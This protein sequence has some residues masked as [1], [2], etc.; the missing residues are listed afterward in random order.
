MEI[1][2]DRD[3]FSKYQKKLIKEYDDAQTPGGKFSKFISMGVGACA[4]AL[5]GGGVP[6]GGAI[7]EAARLP[8]W[9]H[10]VSPSALVAA[11]VVGAAA[12]AITGVILAKGSH[13]YSEENK[14]K[15][16][17]ID[18]ELSPEDLLAKKINTMHKIN[19]M[20]ESARLS[21][22]DDRTKMFLSA[23]F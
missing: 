8:S 15:E 13:E 2:K 12:G 10:F 1:D 23:P 7:L 6:V 11:C 4:V 16:R 14:E 5:F 9:N 3:N 19:T 21:E 22:R 18:V 17:Q 20:R